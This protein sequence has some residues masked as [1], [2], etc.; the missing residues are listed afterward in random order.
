MSS[1]HFEQTPGTPRTRTLFETV[2]LKK[3]HKKSRKC[4]HIN[5]YYLNYLAALEK[6]FIS[7]GRIIACGVVGK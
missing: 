5:Y 2:Y 3:I 4:I 1:W 6:A 7:H